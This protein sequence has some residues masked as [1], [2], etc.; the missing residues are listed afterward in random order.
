MNVA[1]DEIIHLLHSM[2]HGA[3]ATHC[4]R[5]AGYPYATVLP[6]VVDQHHRPVFLISKLAEHTKNLLAN[7]RASLVVFPT[8]QQN[9]LASARATLIGD[10][11][12]FQASATFI[13][14][15]L[16]YQPD[17]QDYLALGDFAFFRF[18]VKRL[19]AI[20]GFGEMG[21]V[22]ADSLAQSATLTLEQESVEL[23][24]APARTLGE[25]KLL[26]VDRYGADLER[27]GVRQRYRFA[28]IPL[29]DEALRPALREA[30]DLPSETAQ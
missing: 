7:A 21:W 6:F 10:V 20:A 1:V 3:L 13:A 23:N 24:A 9:I 12:P 16:R 30:L 14:R 18:D 22:E 8:T 28:N 19:R 15:Y 29:P 2:S 25:L 26:G 27:S 17:A 11:T 4:E 5:M